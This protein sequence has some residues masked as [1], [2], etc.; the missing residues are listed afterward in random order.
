[1]SFAK[2]RT[3]DSQFLDHTGPEIV[4][5]NVCPLDEPI[6]RIEAPCRSQIERERFL[7]AVEDV[8]CERIAMA[9]IRAHSTCIIATFQTLDLD[10]VRP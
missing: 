1:M 10:D 4:H 3:G 7:S 9:E 8:E 6:E 2:R 5:E